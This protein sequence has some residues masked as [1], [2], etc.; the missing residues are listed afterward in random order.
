MAF[1][2]VSLIL[3]SMR[4]VAVVLPIMILILS[5]LSVKIGGNVKNYI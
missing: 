4:L 2:V 3:K 1:L 5:A